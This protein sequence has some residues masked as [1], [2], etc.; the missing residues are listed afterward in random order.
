MA[1]CRFSIDLVGHVGRGEI[2]N[3]SHLSS[4]F[5]LEALKAQTLYIAISGGQV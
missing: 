5:V 3:V 4:N 2:L 1:F